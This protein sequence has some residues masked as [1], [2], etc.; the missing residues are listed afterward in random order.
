M[1]EDRPLTRSAEQSRA[2]VG[3]ILGT[4]GYCA[5]ASEVSHSPL[6]VP[7]EM[8]RLEALK[9][10]NPDTRERS[11]SSL[12]SEAYSDKAPNVSSRSFREVPIARFLT[13]SWGTIPGIFYCHSWQ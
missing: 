7:F 9:G 6:C 1:L 4:E 12:F 5:S 8:L 13:R 3:S 2:C 11:V 10:S